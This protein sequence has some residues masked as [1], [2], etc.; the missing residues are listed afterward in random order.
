MAREIYVEFYSRCHSGEL[1][2]VFGTLP[3]TTSRPYRDDEDLPFMQQSLDIWTSFAR[4]FDPNP[5]P[6]FL[7]ARGF[8]DV[9]EHFAQQGRWEQVTKSNL[10]KAPLRQLQ[11]TSFMTAFKESDQCNFL[12][13]PFSF[14]S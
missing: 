13:F 11:S 3:S 6:Q 1:F 10:Q 4:T 5:D 2:Y 9:A 12:Q 14:F 7:L 8:T